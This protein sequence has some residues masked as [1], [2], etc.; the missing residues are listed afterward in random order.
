MSTSLWKRL[1]FVSRERIWRGIGVFFAVLGALWL[2]FE[3]LTWIT[4]DFAAGHRGKVVLGAA[5]LSSVAAFWTTAPELSARK[6]F[7]SRGV[8]IEL[9]TGNILDLAIN[10]D[11]AVLATDHF[12]SCMDTVISKKS[13]LGQLIMMNFGGNK[14]EFDSQVDR[15]LAQ[16]NIVAQ[17]TK[18]RP[19]GINRPVRY[20]MGS[21]AP[22]HIGTHKAH[23]VAGTRF[24]GKSTM[25]HDLLWN[26]L[27]ALWH[28]V[29]KN[30]HKDPIAVPVWGSSLSNA[31]GN[32]VSLFS[33]VLSSF[34]AFVAQ[35]GLP[36]ARLTIVV[37][38]GDYNASEFTSMSNILSSFEV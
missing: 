33:T 26:S 10:S 3:L 12:D 2:G 30:G 17:P 23:I 32:R 27:M 31:P 37:W 34:A 18:S 1:R 4:S 35:E 11:V 19:F 15:A 7:A 22:L 36:T 16:Q 20:P 5:F 6:H 29:A 14:L 9:V 21:V 25:D 24:D 13:L 38:D 8:S 28:S